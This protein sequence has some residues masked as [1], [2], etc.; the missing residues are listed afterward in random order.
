[1]GAGHGGGAEPPI[2]GVVCVKR[3]MAVVRGMVEGEV[4]TD[5]WVAVEVWGRGI[6]RRRIE[7]LLVENDIGCPAHHHGRREFA[8]DE[9]GIH[10]G[11]A[12]GGGLGG[13]W[14]E[15]PV[16]LRYPR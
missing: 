9:V 8:I 2:V 16:L 11:D 6:F 4:V 14:W 13:V 15:W 5:R 3:G 1:M 7:L 10:A 12:E